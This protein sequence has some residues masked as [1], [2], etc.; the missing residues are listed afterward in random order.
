MSSGIVLL[1]LLFIAYIHSINFPIT[2]KHFAK[3]TEDKSSNYKEN[4]FHVSYPFPL[5]TINICLGSPIVCV[6]LIIDSFGYMG[7]IAT[8]SVPSPHQFNTLKAETLIT[9]LMGDN[10][11]ARKKYIAQ[12]ADFNRVDNFKKNGDEQ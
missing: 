12:Y 7:W 10:V 1:L 5:P 4:N 6:D 8:Q 9:T 2:Y 3:S 11:D